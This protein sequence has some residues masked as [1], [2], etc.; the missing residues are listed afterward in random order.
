MELNTVRDAF[1]RVAKKQKVS[2]SKSQEVIDQVGHEIEQSVA[3]MQST[4]DSSTPVD[5]KSILACC[6]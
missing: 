6:T 2:S 4:Q 5:Q 1:D 3:S